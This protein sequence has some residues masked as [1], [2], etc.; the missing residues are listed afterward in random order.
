M[1]VSLTGFMGSGKSSV[2]AVLS[3]FFDSVYDLD[4]EIC[5]RSSRGISEIFAAEGEEGFRKIEHDVLEALLG[6]ASGRVLISLGGGTLEYAPSAELV[7]RETF[8]I[9]LDVPVD[10]L[11]DNLYLWRGDRPL[12]NLPEGSTREMLRSKIEELLAVREAR[13]KSCAAASVRIEGTD[14]ESAAAQ[15]REL[16]VKF[17]RNH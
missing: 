5:R 10:T 12:L 16:V 8:C 4:T 3:G 15:I 13:Y 6:E 7:C 1:I 2:A 17:S 14:Y 9:R 11:T